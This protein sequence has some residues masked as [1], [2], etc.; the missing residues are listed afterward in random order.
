MRAGITLLPLGE[1]ARFNPGQL[2]KLCDRLGELHAEAEVALALERLSARLAEVGRLAPGGDLA[3]LEPAL[4]A[5]VSD[6]QMIGMAT[7]AAVGRHVLDC[8]GAGDPTALAATL[9]RLERVGDR[10]IH[11]VWDLEDLSG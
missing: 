10:S 11:A 8:L 6:A 3:A 7:L 4:A 5:L 1:P 2:E 9:A